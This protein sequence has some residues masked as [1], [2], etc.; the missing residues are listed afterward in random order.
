MSLEQSEELLLEAMA[1]VVFLLF[2][3][4]SADRFLGRFAHAEG[5]VSL[6]QEYP[7]LLI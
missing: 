1:L 7:V 6:L 2:A 3:D 5:T 4:V